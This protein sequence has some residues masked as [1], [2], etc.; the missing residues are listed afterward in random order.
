MPRTPAPWSLTAAHGQRKYLSPDERRRFLA[1]AESAPVGV[2]TFCLVLAW[3]GCRLSEAL[4]LT[5]GDVLEEAGCLSVR[6]LKKR[7]HE[8]VR[9]I[10]VPP[11]LVDQLVREH[12]GQASAARLWPWPRTTAWRHVKAVMAA[13]EINALPACPRGLRHGFGVHA[14]RSGVPL[15]LVQRWL[16]HADIATTAIYTC[17]LGPEEREIATRMW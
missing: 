10:P 11:A 9:E 1:A 4:A 8:L 12:A 5:R 13:A 2:R 3:S 7:G 17:V 14:V 6:S 16:G 15:D